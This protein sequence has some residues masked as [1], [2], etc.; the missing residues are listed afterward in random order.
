MIKNIQQNKQ[1]SALMMSL[2][3]IALISLVSFAV[4]K[5]VSSEL[6]MSGSHSQ[7][8]AA[9]WAAEAG[10]EK[11][12]LF[13]RLKEENPVYP[14]G[15]TYDND[16]RTSLT[17]L[18][19]RSISRV[20]SAGKA[21]KLKVTDLVD[22]TDE[23]EFVLSKDEGLTLRVPSS[24]STNTVTVKYKALVGKVGNDRDDNDNNFIYLRVI[25]DDGTFNP[26]KY[27]ETIFPPSNSESIDVF[28]S[29]KYIQI[30]AFI[31]NPSHQA[32]ITIK[33]DGYIGGPYTYIQSTGYYH[34]VQKKLEV[35]INR[36]STSVFDIMDYV[37]YSKDDLPQI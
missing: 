29:D 30:K 33:T 24:S 5:V 11:G 34:G 19:D 23:K 15:A 14:A 25:K 37:I 20:D 4:G 9:Y 13:Y 35:K 10:I 3:I 8:K 6:K 27:I 32:K 21:Y 28:P 26:P 16:N 18:D 22:Y 12:L 36:E 1:G 7:Q 17:D 2:L 31:Q